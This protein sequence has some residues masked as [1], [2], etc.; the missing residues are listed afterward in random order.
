MTAEG[1]DALRVLD[2]S[3]DTL[4]FARSGPSWFFSSG[5]YKGWIESVAEAEGA[6]PLVIRLDA[7]GRLCAGLALQLSRD[8]TGRRVISPLSAPWA[9]YHDAIGDPTDEAAVTGLVRLL[10]KLTKAKGAH[11]RLTDVR[12]G[13]LL[14]RV[15]RRL[16]LSERPGS[17]TSAIAL[18]QADPWQTECRRGEYRIKAHRLAR[19]GLLTCQ[20]HADPEAVLRHLPSFIDLHRQQWRGRM[21]A[22]APFCDPTVVRGFEVLANSLSRQGNLILTS[23]TL[24]DRPIAMYFGFRHRGYYGGYRTTFDRSYYRLSPGHLMLHRMLADFCADGVTVFDL[25]RG[26]YG[27]KAAYANLNSHNL[28]YE[29]TT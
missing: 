11:L 9:D 24:A 4:A 29:A 22:V 25:M 3:W 7:G 28:V 16:G 27:Y 23:L 6:E 2:D 1:Q 21:D 12:V 14:E 18:D 20:H 10:S 19:L 26:A 15:A 5:W 8:V 13:G 17:A